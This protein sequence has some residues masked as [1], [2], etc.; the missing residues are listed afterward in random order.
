MSDDWF[1]KYV[2]FASIDKKYLTQEQRDLYKQEPIV[3]EPWDVLA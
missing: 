1:D 3:L 2:Y